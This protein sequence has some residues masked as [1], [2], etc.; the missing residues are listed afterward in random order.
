MS[1]SLLTAARTAL[2]QTATA[3]ANS[4]LGM[5]GQLFQDQSG[6][7]KRYIQSED[8]LR[9]IGRKRKACA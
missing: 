7:S 3:L 1:L 5:L 8:D 2:D 4:S 6:G 9:G